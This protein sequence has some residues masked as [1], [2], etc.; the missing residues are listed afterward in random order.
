MDNNKPPAVLVNEAIRFIKK[1]WD[2]VSVET[3]RNCWYHSGLISRDL[4]LRHQGHI[5][6]I[7]DL[8]YHQHTK[9]IIVPNINTLG[10]KLEE[11]SLHNMDRQTKLIQYI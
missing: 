4:N 8:C 2:S 11:E 1:A 5:L 7:R 10:Q 3:I 9:A 6:A